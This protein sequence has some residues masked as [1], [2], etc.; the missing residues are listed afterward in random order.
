MD[1]YQLL[2][3]AIVTQ[4]ADDYFNILAGFPIT[5]PPRQGSDQG[6]P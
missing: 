1:G 3:N 6:K 4:A 5:P 2:A